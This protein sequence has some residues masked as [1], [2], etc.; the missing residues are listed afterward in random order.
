MLKF[1][2]GTTE[3]ITYSYE[4]KPD[5]PVF[6]K[7]CGLYF[8]ATENNENKDEKHK[9]LYTKVFDCDKITYAM[10][11]RNR[12][13]GDKITVSSEGKTKKLKDIF[14]DRKIPKD[15]RNLVPVVS[16][17]KD[18][19]WLVGIRDS[20]DFVPKDKNK[21]KIYIKVWGKENG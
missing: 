17:G 9:Y 8:L 12:I 13:D 15:E 21:R 11:V 7:E 19:I 4:L 14:I 2:F 20:A 6:V 3:K 10:V 5:E 16:S 18:V 1:Y